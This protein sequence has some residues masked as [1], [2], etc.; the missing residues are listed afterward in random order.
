LSFF[1]PC[2]MRLMDLTWAPEHCATSWRGTETQHTAYHAYPHQTSSF[3]P[4]AIWSEAASAALS[5]SASCALFRGRDSRSGPRRRRFATGCMAPTVEG[6]AVACIEGVQVED[7][8]HETKAVSRRT[9]VLSPTLLL[10]HTCLSLCKG[11]SLSN[12]VAPW[13][14]GDF[15]CLPVT[16]AGHDVTVLLGGCVTASNAGWR[17]STKASKPSEGL[18]K[19]DQ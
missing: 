18:S 14:V 10:Q 5:S 15:I 17:V 2:K 12:L 11:F 4:L 8:E 7:K 13:P 6:V 16:A 19:Q 9:Q 1:V 3:K